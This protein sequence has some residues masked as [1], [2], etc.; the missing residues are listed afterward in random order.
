MIEN[1]PVLYGRC[2]GILQESNRLPHGRYA[3]MT[4]LSAEWV[5]YYDVGRAWLLAVLAHVCRTHSEWRERD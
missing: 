2:G 5:H 4:P 1:I 3:D